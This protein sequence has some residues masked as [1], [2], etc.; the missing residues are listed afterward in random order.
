MKNLIFAFVFL[1]LAAMSCKKDDERNHPLEY[2]VWES[3]AVGDEIYLFRFTDAYSCSYV[4]YPNGDDPYH[5]LWSGLGYRVEDHNVK[6]WDL[7]LADRYSNPP[8]SVIWLQGYFSDDVMHL[9]NDTL[10]L[11]LTKIKRRGINAHF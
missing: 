11:E 4:A 5:Y 3:L 8:N 9:S 10:K 7:N 6:I 1:L 2:T